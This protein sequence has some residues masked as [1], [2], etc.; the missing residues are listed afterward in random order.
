MRLQAKVQPQYEWEGCSHLHHQGDPELF[1]QQQV[2]GPTLSPHLHSAVF[3]QPYHSTQCSPAYLLDATQAS[4]LLCYIQAW[5]VNIYVPVSHGQLRCYWS[6]IQ[7]LWTVFLVNLPFWCSVISAAFKDGF[8]SV[9]PLPLSQWLHSCWRTNGYCYK[10][11][12]PEACN[13]WSVAKITSCD[14]NLIVY[15]HL[16]YYCPLLIPDS[17]A[18]KS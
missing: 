18:I 11:F 16:T 6:N 9:T 10:P 4:Q 7:K 2:S 17:A 1:P 5:H 8:I 15:N 3:L 12:I 14:C 13:L